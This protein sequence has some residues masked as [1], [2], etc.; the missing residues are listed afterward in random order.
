M[1]KG[2][3]NAG[4]QFYLTP[5]LTSGRLLAPSSCSGCT[6]RHPAVSLCR[7]YRANLQGRPGIRFWCLWQQHLRILFQMTIW[8]HHRDRLLYSI[9][10]L[11]GNLLFCYFSSVQM[12]WECLSHFYAII[13]LEK[14]FCKSGANF[15]PRYFSAVAE[16]LSHICC[17]RRRE[18][19]SNSS[20]WIQV[21]RSNLP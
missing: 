10:R 8:E 2:A 15:R 19:A 4:S 5:S 18:S 11:V 21:P 3:E 16:I 6:A 20:S 7:N 14:R 1:H 13:W 9:S 17:W 12:N